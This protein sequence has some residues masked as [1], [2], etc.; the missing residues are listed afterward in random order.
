MGRERRRRM[1]R[2]GMVISRENETFYIF[3]LYTTTT[4]FRV[5]F[6]GF[7]RSK[8]ITYRLTSLVSLP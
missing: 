8:F 4:R 5:I 1:G 3:L 2:G 6:T 7:F